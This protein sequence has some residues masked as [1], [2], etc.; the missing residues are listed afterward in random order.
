MIKPILFGFLSMLIGFLSVILIDQYFFLMTLKNDVAYI[1]G[2][3]GIF[4]IVVL[5]IL[6]L[7][8]LIKSAFKSI[9]K[10]KTK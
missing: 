9:I 4:I 2:A 6:W 7:R 3:S 1:G 5:M 8:F 10:G